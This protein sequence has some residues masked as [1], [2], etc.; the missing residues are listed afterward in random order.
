MEQQV[1][2]PMDLLQR[3]PVHGRVQE[4]DEGR[5]EGEGL[6]RYGLETYKSEG[7]IF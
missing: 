2:L 7:M 5:N 4:A 6:L 3:R 1:Q